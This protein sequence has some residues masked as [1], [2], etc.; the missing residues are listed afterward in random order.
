[1]TKKVNTVTT[2]SLFRNGRNQALRLPEAL[3]FEGTSEV[4]VRSEGNSII[5]RLL[6]FYY[7]QL[8]NR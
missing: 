6:K 4:E 7:N 5:L 8:T 1:M 2:A 3:E